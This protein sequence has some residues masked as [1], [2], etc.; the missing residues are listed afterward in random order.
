MNN[1]RQ[2]AE[3]QVAPYTG[4]WIETLPVSGVKPRACSVAPY[5]GAWI[6]TPF[7][8]DTAKVV[9]IRSLPTRGRG[10]KLIP[11]KTIVA[12]YTGA[13][14][15]TPKEVKRMLSEFVSLPTRGRGLKPFTSSRD[16][17]RTESLPTR[18]RGLKPVGSEPLPEFDGRSLHGGVD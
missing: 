2:I 9:A 1:R 4:A 7:S 17:V 6:E 15:E 14:I 18:G 13:W 8:G 16:S 3:L 10:L 5:T 11:R 12:P